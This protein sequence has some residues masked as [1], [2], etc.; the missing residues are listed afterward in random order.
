MRVLVTRA[1]EDAARTAAR[2]AVCGHET[3]L[4]P[5]IEIVP[6]GAILP[7]EIFDGVIAT[8]AHAFAGLAQVPR[9]LRSTVLLVAGSRTAEAAQRAG[10]GV[11]E[12]VA[13]D[14]QALLAAMAENFPEPFRF[15]YLAGR[16]RKPDLERDLRARGHDVTIVETYV[17]Q[18]ASAL[19]DAAVAALRDERLDTVL[20]FSPRSAAIFVDLVARAGLSSNAARVRHIAISDDSAQPLRARSWHVDVAATPDEDA[21]LACLGRSQSSS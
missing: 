3:I 10:F 19:S 1:A 18:A 20:H 5:V 15:L 9:A 8:S 4:S 14:V 2:L 16:D 6:T 17:A 21:V 7:E 12:T 13:V 11:A